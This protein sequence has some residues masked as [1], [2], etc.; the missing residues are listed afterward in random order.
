VFEEGGDAV[1]GVAVL[2]GLAGFLAHA[3]TGR[4]V[5]KE[6]DQ[7]VGQ[8]LRVAERHDPTGLSVFDELREAAAGS[9]D[10]RSALPHG[11]EHGIAAAFVA[12]GRMDQEVH[13][14]VHVTEL[15]NEAQEANRIS[16][17]QL[18]HR[19]LQRGA[20]LALSD[21]HELGVRYRATHR[22]PGLEQD[23]VALHGREPT[24]GGDEQGIGVE[25]EPGAEAL[26]VANGRPFGVDRVGDVHEVSR[27][28]EVD[29][30]QHPFADGD[31]I[32]D[33][34]AYVVAVEP[35]VVARVLD[36]TQQS[37]AL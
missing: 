29:A 10:A 34:S 22:R 32:D 25:P 33:H 16:H 7:G 19:R 26:P 13:G 2:D 6:A 3:L 17:A 1:Q 15:A 21:Q 11:L 4:G 5:G 20:L 24:D 18:G 37:T 14:V 23:L 36:G 30:F 28:R 12:Q 8:R 31:G 9:D 35:A 27:V